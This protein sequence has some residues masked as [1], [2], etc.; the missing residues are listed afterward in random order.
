MIFCN[1]NLITGKKLCQKFNGCAGYG[2]CG[3]S[4]PPFFI[5]H[6]WCAGIAWRHRWYRLTNFTEKAVFIWS[7]YAWGIFVFCHI[8]W[9]NC[10]QNLAGRV[11]NL[12]F[13]DLRNKFFVKQTCQNV[14]R[15]SKSL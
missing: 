7:L 4:V 6:T 8:Q 13:S 9:L 11:L 5:P 15:V 12:G 2:G 14:E 3:L 10:L 1:L